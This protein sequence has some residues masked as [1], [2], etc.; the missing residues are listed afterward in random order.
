[1]SLEYFSLAM[2][3]MIRELE[4]N[5]PLL[6]RLKLG[7]DVGWSFHGQCLTAVIPA[8]FPQQ[9]YLA[10]F[11]AL[12]LETSCFLILAGLITDRCQQVGG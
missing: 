1:M 12:N 3:K 10:L 4:E 5:F 11:R 9:R 7:R 2:L 6:I 8:D